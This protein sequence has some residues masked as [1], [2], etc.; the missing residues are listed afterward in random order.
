ME[1]LKVQNS[2]NIQASR[3]KV[4]DALTNP[5]QTQKYM[6]GCEALSDW[7]VGSPLL[8]QG[9]YEGQEM[10]FVKGE[11]LEIEQLSSLKYSVIDPNAPYEDLP[12]NYL[13]V[14]YTLSDGENS[15]I[16]K[17]VQDGFED[18]ADGQKRYEDVRNNGDG[19]NPILKAIKQLVEA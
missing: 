17:V 15:T 10:V 19:W 3:E 5:Q 16:L 12:Q 7:K 6:F 8:W 13:N 9:Y 2:I 4:W 14:H 11:I 18:A 1:K